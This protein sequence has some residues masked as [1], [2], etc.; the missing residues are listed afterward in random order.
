MFVEFH[1]KTVVVC[2]GRKGVCYNG[3]MIISTAMMTWA[4][5][6]PKSSNCASGEREPI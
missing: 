6:T 2:T 1:G 4:A 5:S 3:L